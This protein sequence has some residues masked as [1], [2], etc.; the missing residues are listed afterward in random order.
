VIEPRIFLKDRRKLVF[1]PGPARRALRSLR[2]SDIVAGGDSVSVKVTEETDEGVVDHGLDFAYADRDGQRVAV[3]VKLS[4]PSKDRSL[5]A[6]GLSQITRYTELHRDHFDRAELWT[7]TKTG[8]QLT[9]WQPDRELSLEYGLANVV[10]TEDRTSF[11]TKRRKPI[12]SDYIEGRANRWKELVETV[13]TELSDWC[14]V[15]DY[16]VSHTGTTTMDEELMQLFGVDP[17]SLPILKIS[18][19]NVAIANVLPIGLWVIGGSGRIDVLTRGRS[20]SIINDSDD[21]NVARW[22]LYVAKSPASILSQ[23][24]FIN[25]ISEP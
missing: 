20:A 9:I 7:L 14:R 18:K 13:F 22:K 12:D 25:F 17:I 23:Q 1:E 10:S 5:V 3:E 6:R 19:N 16:H 8:A 4:P 21:P 2:G 11:D 15:H 24:S